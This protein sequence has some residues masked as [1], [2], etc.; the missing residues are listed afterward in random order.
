MIYLIYA[1]DCKDCDQMRAAIHRAIQECSINCPIEEI[2]S[3]NERAIDIAIDNNID[4]LPACVIGNF[5]FCGKNGYT[6]Q[7]IKS[8]IEQTFK[9]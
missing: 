7:D 8:S 4:D 6:Y 2:D 3:S 1:P 5:S 9:K